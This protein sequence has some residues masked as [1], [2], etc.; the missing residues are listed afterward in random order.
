MSVAGYA[1]DAG[2]QHRSCQRA[3]QLDSLQ[4][5]I[6]HWCATN[7]AATGGLVDVA[8]AEPLFRRALALDPD[9]RV[10]WRGLAWLRRAEGRLPESEA[11]FDSALAIAPWDIG[12]RERAYIR[13]LRGNIAG[14]QADQSEGDRIRGLRDSSRWALFATVA[15]DSA[16]ARERLT[17]ARSPSDPGGVAFWSAVFRLRTEVLDALERLRATPD[18]GGEATCA[19]ATPCSVSLR[20]WRA[21][22]DPIYAYLRDEPRFLRLKEETRPRIP[23]LKR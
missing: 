17:R 22:H 6:W 5:E 21:L 11:L 16:P 20:T 10:S 7:Y 19:P 3:L 23:W 1:L 4:A 18:P 13:F 15:G 14:A 9:M 2:A 8:M 12:L